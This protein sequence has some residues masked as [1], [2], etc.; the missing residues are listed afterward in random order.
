[1]GEKEFFFLFPRASEE[2]FEIA[3]ESVPI[4]DG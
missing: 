3:A 1:M 4:G 2:W